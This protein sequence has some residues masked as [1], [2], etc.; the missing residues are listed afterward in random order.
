MPIAKLLFLGANA[1]NTTRLRL[2][3]ELRDI[4][5]ALQITGLGDA[6]QLAAELAVR[7]SDLQN[8]LL[9]HTPSM[10]H[11]SGHGSNSSNGALE[12]V[13]PAGTASREFMMSEE[14]S[15]DMVADSRGGLLFEDEQGAAVVVRPDVL[16]ALLATMKRDIPLRCVVLNACFTALQAQAIAEHI[17]C[18]IATTREVEDDAAIA[19]ATAFYRA[20]AYGKSVGSAFELGRIEVGLRGLP[21]EGVFRLFHRPQVEPQQLFLV[22]AASVRY[23]HNEPP[24]DQGRR[25][26][27]VHW[28]H[29][30]EPARQFR[31]HERFREELLAWITR[32]ELST[33]VFAIC[34]GAGTGKTALEDRVLRDWLGE[35]EKQENGL[36]AG[37]FVWSFCDNDQVDD[38]WGEASHYFTGPEKDL[39]LRWSRLSAVLS[40]GRPHLF[41]LDGLDKVQASARTGRP[42]GEI[43][44]IRLRGWIRQIAAAQLGKTRLLLTS[45]LPPCDISGWEGSGYQKVDLDELDSRAKRAV[46]SAKATVQS[47]SISSI[48]TSDVPVLVAIVNHPRDS[49][50]RIALQVRLAPMVRAQAIKFVPDPLATKD[51]KTS[52]ERLKCAEVVLVLLTPDLV[53]ADGVVGGLFH[54]AEFSS[55]AQIV[56]PILIR[57]CSLWDSPLQQREL[58]RFNQKA[59]TSAVDTDEA[60]QYIQV[61]LFELFAAVCQRKA[62]GSAD[63]SRFSAG[64]TERSLPADSITQWL[65]ATLRAP[66]SNAQHEPRPQN[67]ILYRMI[68]SPKD[69]VGHTFQQY[70]VL[71]FLG[72]G[73]TGACYRV[74]HATLGRDLCLKLTY[75]LAGVPQV[76]LMA[77][78]RTVRALG[79]IDHPCIIKPRD[80]GVME[81]DGDSTFYVVMDLLSHRSVERWVLEDEPSL[82]KILN[83]F[84][85][86]AD[87][88]HVAHNCRYFDE[89]GLEQVGLL[90]GDIK[91]DNIIMT[92]SG[93]P[94][95]TDF[96]M[97]DLHALMANDAIKRLVADGG[98]LCRPVTDTYGTPGYMPPEQ[99]SQG[100]LTVRSDVYSFGK[101]TFQAIA[102][103]YGT[104]FEL[105][106]KYDIFPLGID[107]DLEAYLVRMTSSLP[108][109]RP[110][111]MAQVAN[112]FREFARRLG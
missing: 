87:A 31:G 68:S 98:P 6:F 1:R 108:E 26:W 21:G 57:P 11:F 44:D 106:E 89:T 15:S 5:R 81:V 3:A 83:T 23:D 37:V 12:P 101:T 36:P 43:L 29:A 32:P 47:S 59:L 42:E 46:S 28:A 8:L 39:E 62:T 104:S 100:L 30:L 69:A 92:R 70:R 111:N 48:D 109:E 38:F 16:T 76:I 25:P 55:Q 41:V 74:Q 73:G 85:K 77:V 93:E 52:V 35:F 107:V 75:P 71:E 105:E 65:A 56:V 84:A 13:S 17:D 40:D 50:H 88:M 9:M 63:S 67:S 103:R 66:N 2:G 110:S 22:H 54:A 4:Q 61:C 78:S 95:V 20:I 94:V 91:P 45:R 96:M 53:A 51:I 19:F 27:S 33:R 99:S 97:P 102:R 60:W 49:S 72:Q 10:L 79:I 24:H 86:L 14:T 112:Q 18:V 82:A 80:F 90:H 7:P 64:N 58:L 34:G